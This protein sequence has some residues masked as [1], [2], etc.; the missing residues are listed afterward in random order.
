MSLVNVVLSGR[1]LRD[2]T[3]PGPEESHLIHVFLTQC[4]QETS[5]EAS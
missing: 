2:G 4:D 1:G 5:K 3:I